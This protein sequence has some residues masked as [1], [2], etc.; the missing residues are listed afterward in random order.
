MAQPS[1]PIILIAAQDVTLP[2]G[3]IPNKNKPP[4]VYTST[5][6]DENQGL[7][8][9]YLNYTFHNLGQWTKYLHEEFVPE[10][11]AGLQ[12]QIS[13]LADV[14]EAMKIKVGGYYLGGSA[15]PSTHL[16]YGTWEQAH[17]GLAIVGVGSH[18]DSRGESK[19]W[20]DGQV[21]GEYQHVQTLNELVSHVHTINVMAADTA[22]NGDHIDSTDETNVAG[23]ETTDSTGGG[24]PMNNIQPSGAMYIWKRTA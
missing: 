23:K 24:D 10:S 8:A 6:W 4:A 1:E 7:A 21:E 16:G 22:N 3:Q 12:Q 14:V 5:G 19:T 17:Q 13:Q 18:T 11:V 15:N 20:T 9:D 2:V